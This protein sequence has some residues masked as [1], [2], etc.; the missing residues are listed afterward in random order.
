MGEPA[1]RD[2]VL[3]GCVD[4]LEAGDRAIVEKICAEHP[5]LAEDIRSVGMALAGLGAERPGAWALRSIGSF[6]TGL[7]DALEFAVCF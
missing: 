7:S 1:D 3:A 4:A 6:M 2:A 5:S